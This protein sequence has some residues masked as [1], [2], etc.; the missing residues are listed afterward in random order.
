MTRV[1]VDLKPAFDGLSGIPIE[2]RAL[3]ASLRRLPQN[4]VLIDGL[5]QAGAAVLP[6]ASG[7]AGPDRVIGAARTVAALDAVRPAGRLNGYR[8]LA[9]RLRHERAITRMARRGRAVRL[10]DFPADAF[11]DFLWRGLFAASLPP[12]D[13]AL[14]TAPGFKTAWVPRSDFRLAWARTGKPL[15]LDTRGY[16]AFVVQSPF[17]G[18]AAPGT[19]LIVRY[20]DAVPIYLPHT[21]QDRQ[22]HLDIFEQALRLNVADGA[23]FACVSEAARA[24]LLRLFPEAEPR[25]RVIPNAVGAPFGEAG[26]GPDAIGGIVAR[27]G[28]GASWSASEGSPLRYLLAVGTLEPR[29]NHALLVRAWERAREA[30][31][32]L[33]LVLVGGTGWESEEVLAAFAPWRA[34][35]AAAHLTGV[36]TRELA[37]LYAH[38]ALT[39]CPSIYEGFDYPGVEALRCGGAVLA[40]DIPVH[41]EVLGEAAAYYPPYD[42]AACARAILAL[43]GEAG[44]SRRAAMR[45]AAPGVTARYEADGLRARWSDLLLRG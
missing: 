13:A 34:T 10:A 25:A 35:G 38:A 32:H 21:I 3:F 30:D 26:P 29:K 22:R 44:A 39:V 28:G 19:R 41:R 1:L 11:G 42:D 45:D 17:P 7:T 6:E 24:D 9:R 12:G 36:P 18:Q 43:T 16:D 4:T 5:I 31:S 40:S 20:H 8:H 37:A 33:R 15:T 27:R 2:T 23:E 14:V